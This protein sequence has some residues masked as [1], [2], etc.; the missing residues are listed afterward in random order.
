MFG[1]PRLR[2][3]MT[4]RR[5]GQ[6]AARS[7]ARDLHG[8][9]GPDWEQEDDITLVTLRRAAGVSDQARR[10]PTVTTGSPSRRGR[11]RAPGRW[12]AWPRR[13]PTRP[14]AGR[15]ERLKTAV[16]EA[17]MNAIEYGS[18]GR[19]DVPST[20]RSRPRRRDRS[21]ASPI[22]PCPDRARRRRDP[23]IELKLAGDQKPRGWGLFL[24][25]NMVDSMDVTTDGTTQT[26]TLTMARKEPSDG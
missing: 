18:Q 12:T 20:S 19:A 14:R 6:R 2:E 15:L 21:C 3:A 17:T 25:K 13:S 23:D 16:S 9:T 4:H 5:R 24:I 10:R 11:Q 26:V 22:A 1:F 7:A 8:F